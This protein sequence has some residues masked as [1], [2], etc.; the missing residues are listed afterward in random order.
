MTI[1]NTPSDFEIHEKRRDRS[2]RLRY[3][4][5][6]VEISIIMRNYYDGMEADDVQKVRDAF[7][8]NYFG[9]KI[10]RKERLIIIQQQ[11]STVRR[12]AARYNPGSGENALA[13]QFRRL[14]LISRVVKAGLAEGNVAVDAVDFFMGN[15]CLNTQNLSF[16][17]IQKK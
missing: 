11:E 1:E 2:E 5:E 3:L 15:L 9:D 12:F 10:N 7:H 13:T 14:T 4:G 8:E 16:S 17:R 6:V